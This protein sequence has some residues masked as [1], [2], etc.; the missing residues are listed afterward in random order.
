MA[1]ILSGLTDPTEHH[2]HILYRAWEARDMSVGR[3][4][5][6]SEINAKS[7]DRL[8]RVLHDKRKWFIREVGG[9]RRRV[10]RSW[11]DIAHDYPGVNHATLR[12]VLENRRDPKDNAIR[13]ALGL[14]IYVSIMVCPKCGK[15]HDE[16]KTCP[17]KRRR[18]RHSDQ[19]IADMPV[20]VLAWKLR[21]RTEYKP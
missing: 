12:A 11:R 16:I 6:F 17:D 20:S 7:L 2:V 5:R 21:N 8:Q 13:R 19:R 1:G 18:I 3:V 9:R 4:D 10:R 14:P 15:R